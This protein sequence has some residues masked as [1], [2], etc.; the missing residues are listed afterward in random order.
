MESK[1]VS[2]MKRNNLSLREVGR[3]INYIQ[4]NDSNNA[5]EIIALP[6]MLENNLA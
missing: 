4:L 6:K 1:T 2:R 5:T 3:D